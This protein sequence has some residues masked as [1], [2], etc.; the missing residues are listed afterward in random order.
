MIVRKASLVMMAAAV[1]CML[2]S[3]AYAV[4]Y[5]YD[6]ENRLV[7]ARFDDGVVEEYTYDLAGNRE[8]KHRFVSAN[9]VPIAEDQAVATWENNP[10]SITLVASD[11][12]GDP[13]T[14]LIE[15]EPGHGVLSGT[16][17]NLTYTPHTQ[18]DGRDS[19]QF[20]A[21]DGE[22]DSTVATVS[23][24][25]TNV[26]IAPIA[27]D[28]CLKTRV[29]RPISFTLEAED[30]DQEPCELSYTMMTEPVNGVLSGAAPDLTYT[31]NTGF[32][33][34]ETFT[35]KVNDGLEDS[36]IATVTIHM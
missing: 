29:A 28:Q 30:P 5:Q 8:V 10:C 27:Y 12:D 32:E 19:F 33:G 9:T 35:F 14:F 26:N 4:T 18:Y 6:K 17:P 13:L 11:A 15:T 24:I 22:D 25:I 1:F 7:R 20:K 31:P 16:P 23:I 21:N 3:T 2:C 36:N 34:Q